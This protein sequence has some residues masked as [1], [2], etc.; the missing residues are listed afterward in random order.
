MDRGYAREIQLLYNAVIAA[1][2]E[3]RTNTRD[4]S[5]FPSFFSLCHTGSF[6]TTTTPRGTSNNRLKEISRKRTADSFPQR[7]S[8][9]SLLSSRKQ[10]YTAVNARARLFD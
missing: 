5:Y 8:S 9:S 3:M 4:F 2:T 1:D 7:S 6:V 10:Y